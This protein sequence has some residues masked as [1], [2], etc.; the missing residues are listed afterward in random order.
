[1]S[2][3]QIKSHQTEEI[4]GKLTANIQVGIQKRIAKHI[5]NLEKVNDARHTTGSTSH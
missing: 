1:M 3:I 4:L 5:W 2:R